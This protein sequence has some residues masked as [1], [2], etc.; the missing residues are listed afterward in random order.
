MMQ[1]YNKKLLDLNE[2][3]R[4]ALQIVKYNLLSSHEQITM[5]SLISH[6]LDVDKVTQRSA[7]FAFDNRT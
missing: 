6:L 3:L 1:E 5:L 7:T 4:A 2:P